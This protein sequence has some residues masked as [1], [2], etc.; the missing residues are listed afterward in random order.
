M[1][2][3]FLRIR[4][5]RARKINLVSVAGV[6][7]GVMAMIVIL[8]VMKGF[9]VELRERIRGTLSHVVVR[10]DFGIVDYAEVLRKIEAVE[11]VEAV[12]PYVETLALIQAGGNSTWTMVRGVDPDAEATIGDFEKYCLK[13]LEVTSGVDEGMAFVLKG[14]GP[15][16]IG[17]HKPET[18]DPA[19]IRIDDDLVPDRQ[20]EVLYREGQPYLKNL[21]AQRPTM[22]NSQELSGEAPLKHDDEIRV[23]G[24][25]LLFRDSFQLFRQSIREQGVEGPAHDEAERPAPE[26]DA[27]P[28]RGPEAEPEPPEA[29]RVEDQEQTSEERGEGNEA[30]APART[31]EP[32][33]EGPRD[34]PSLVEDLPLEALS[35]LDGSPAPPV[36]LGIALLEFLTRDTFIQLVAPSGFMEFRPMEFRLTGRFKTGNYENDSRSIYIPLRDAQ[37][38]AGYADKVSGI[39]VRLDDYRR[40]ERAVDTLREALGPGFVVE[41]WEKQRE[42]LLKA[43]DNERRVMAVVLLFITIVAGFGIMAAL[44][45]MVTEKTRDIGIVKSI[46]GTVAGIMGI[47]L[48]NG[49]LIGVV[50]ASVGVL[51]GLGFLEIMNPLADWVYRQFGWHVFPPTLYYLDHIP[52]SKDPS[53]IALI[54]LSAV[55]ISFLAALYP[56]LKAARLDPVEALRYE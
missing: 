24:T 28:E 18:Q 2:K 31:D 10:N 11:H 21:A 25:T 37:A 53:A 36:L 16:L 9:G 47:F 34:A 23:G 52:A 35:L 12:A 17:R 14:T 43:I 1:Y 19:D 38:L 45:M 54:A 32:E 13:F 8:S 49:T 41:T 33:P 51:A 26:R 56:A 4:Y 48:V 30:A 39:S 50:G 44:W 3:L 22:L 42:I 7:V 40:A 20:A 46:G 55:A 6:I 15:L 29:P 5:L 27:E